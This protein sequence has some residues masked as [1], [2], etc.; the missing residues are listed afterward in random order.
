MDIWDE[1]GKEMHREIERPHRKFIQIPGPNP[2]L[3]R[4]KK[5]SWDEKWI[6]CCDVF[7]DYETYYLYYHGV[8][9]DKKTWLRQSYRIGVATSSHP[10]GPWRKYEKNPILDLGEEGSW[11]DYHVACA[12]IIKEGTDKYYMWY[13]GMGSKKRDKWSIGLATASSPL[14]PWKKYKDNPV[15]EDFGYV[16][17][18]VKVKGKYYMYTEHPIG[19]TGPDYGPIALAKAERPEGPWIKH[20]GNPVLSSGDWGSW[21]DGGFSEGEVTYR[22]GIFHIFYGGAKLHPTRIQTRESIG[23]AYSFDGYKFTKYRNNPVALRERNP[24]ASAFAEVHSF[25]EPPFIFLY[26]T[27][28]YISRPEIEDIGVQVLATSTPF[29]LAMPILNLNSLKAGTTTSLENCP[30]ISL[31]HISELAITVECT[32]H[33][34]AKKGLRIHLR[35]SYDGIHYDTENLYTFDNDF[36]PGQTIGKTVELSP[37]VMFIKIFLENLDKAKDITNVKVTA[38]LG[39]K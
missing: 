10:L 29:R 2:I 15:L 3:R 16:G 9:L 35:A 23:Y 27:L 11:D 19:S 7:K 14:G 33:V 24:D 8:P 20:K 12:S 26:H 5:G 28:R 32:Y 1:E 34:K 21:D 39:G 31:E 18:V 17:G 13:S 6:E 4:G 36:K 30:P 37:K 25:F 38:T 22:E